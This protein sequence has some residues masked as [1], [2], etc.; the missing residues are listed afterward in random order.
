[1]KKIHFVIYPV[2]MVRRGQ[3]LFNQELFFTDIPDESG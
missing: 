2:N 3:A 1:M